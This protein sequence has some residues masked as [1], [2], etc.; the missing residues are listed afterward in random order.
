MYREI[1]HLDDY[2]YLD[3]RP[4][5][6]PKRECIHTT[7]LSNIGLSWG[8]WRAADG[9]Q[10]AS[11]SEGLASCMA[12][13]KRRDLEDDSLKVLKQMEMQY[14]VLKSAIGPGNEVLRQS[15]VMMEPMHPIQSSPKYAED[16]LSANSSLSR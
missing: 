1:I 15:W 5:W 4:A 3:R 13:G 2:I 14:S 9:R 6:A 8:E 10:L 7:L 16:S 12:A 11:D